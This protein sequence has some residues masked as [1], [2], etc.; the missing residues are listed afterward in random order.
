MSVGI[1]ET[2]DADALLRGL[3]RGLL[4]DERRRRV[5][6]VTRAK[7]SRA[8][9]SSRPAHRGIGLANEVDTSPSCEASTPTNAASSPRLGDL[10]QENGV[11]GG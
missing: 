10:N 4:D 2:C 3:P 6:S 1:L 5:G 8:Y 11:G 7:G 9:A